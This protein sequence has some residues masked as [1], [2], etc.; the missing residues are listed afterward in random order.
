MAFVEGHIWTATRSE[1]YHYL[2][3]LRGP[4]WGFDILIVAT[5]SDRSSGFDLPALTAEHMGVSIDKAKSMPATWLEGVKV[6]RQIQQYRSLS[7]TR[8]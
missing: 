8:F 6:R 1:C 7:Q 4:P 2:T 3:Q 5:K